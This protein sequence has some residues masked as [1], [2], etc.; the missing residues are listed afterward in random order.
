MPTQK[1]NTFFKKNLFAR[2]GAVR[3]TTALTSIKPPLLQTAIPPSLYT[4][5][6]VSGFF[7]HR[8]YKTKTKG[9]AGGTQVHHK[10]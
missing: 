7:L 10:N 1:T 5:R 4:D 8:T 6:T 3:A 9:K 2:L